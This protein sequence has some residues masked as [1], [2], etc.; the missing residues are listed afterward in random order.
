[1]DIL[2]HVR[3]VREISLARKFQRILILGLAV[4]SLGGAA[5]GFK[6]TY[7]PGANVCGH[8]D[9]EEECLLCHVPVHCLSANRCQACH[10]EIAKERTE[11]SGLHGKLP[12]T[13]QCQNCHTEHQGRDA[14]ITDVAFQNIDHAALTGFSL[15]HHQHETAETAMTCQ[16]CHPQGEFAA[17][18][19]PCREC[20][21]DADA[22]FMDAHERE[23]GQRC[24][25]C[26][27]GTGR[28]RDFQ[29]DAVFPLE[30]VHA[31]H[32]CIACHADQRYVKTARNCI[33]CHEEPPVHAGAFGQACHRCHTTNG[34]GNAQ[35]R[36]HIF[37]LDHGA[38]TASACEV[39]H[40]ETYTR[41]TCYGCHDAH[42]PTLAQARHPDTPLSDLATCA[43]CHPTGEVEEVENPHD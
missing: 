14:V 1:M 27:D 20:H 23:F 8:A 18:A 9:F 41:Y 40:E 37:P 10:K 6:K 36:E 22:A 2:K 26:H 38:E 34:W 33:D 13:N 42:T 12:G 25:D 43:D 17:A 15:E 11:A 29:H 7:D 39:C 28:M 19:V 30:G 21:A 35:L 16:S 5:Y 3:S 31:E 4:L 24:L 32:D